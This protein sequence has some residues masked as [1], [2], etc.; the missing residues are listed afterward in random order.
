M[1]RCRDSSNGI[2]L[3]VL[4]FHRLIINRFETICWFVSQAR[5]YRAY[6]NRVLLAMTRREPIRG[7]SAPASM[8]ATVT[9]SNTQSMFLSY[10]GRQEL[11]LKKIYDAD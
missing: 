6:M 4:L 3:V 10:A 7:G 2:T 11:Q 1:V 9:A 5:Q 8:L